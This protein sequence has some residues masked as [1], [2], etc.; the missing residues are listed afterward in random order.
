MTSFLLFTLYAPLVSWGEITV[1]D[2]RGSWDR[3]S[4]SAIM[5]LVAASLG[6]TREEQ[7]GH[8]SLDQGYGIAIRLDAVGVSATDY[9]TVQSAEDSELRKAF[10]K[11]GPRTR[12]DVL[13]LDDRQTMVT[14]RELRLDALST[15]AIWANEAPPRWTLEELQGSLRRPYFVLYAGRKANALAL[16]LSPLVVTAGSLAD[17]FATRPAFPPGVDLDVLKPSQE[18]WGREVAYDRL[19]D[20]VSAGLIHLRREMRRDSQ[21]NRLRWQFSDRSVNVGLLPVGAST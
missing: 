10:G 18:G 13:S 2:N 7:A 14:R 3:P 17:A 11:V 8:D 15:V 19:P 12:K 21:A 20:G 16:P 1:G 6:I 4:R 9:Q 5:G